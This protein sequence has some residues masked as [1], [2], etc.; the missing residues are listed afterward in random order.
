MLLFIL[1]TAL[2]SL[3][4]SPSSASYQPTWD[5][6]DARPIP[7]WYETSK[8]GIFC[9]WGVYSVPSLSSEWF[10]WAWKGDHPSAEIAAFMARNFKPGFSYADF[11]PMFTAEFFDPDRFADIIKH[12]GANFSTSGVGDRGWRDWAR[13]LLNEQKDG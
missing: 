11:G 13:R 4:F 12:S 6:L 9:H 1:L 7:D 10:W 3:T 8:F 5:S 2:L